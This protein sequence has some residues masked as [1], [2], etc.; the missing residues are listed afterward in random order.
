VG[1]EMSRI[2]TIILFGTFVAISSGCQQHTSPP[3]RTPIPSTQPTDP[4]SAAKAEIRE[5][6]YREL[7]QKIPLG[8]TCYLSFGETKEGWIDPTNEFIARFADTGLRIGKPSQM[9]LKQFAE[10]DNRHILDPSTHT[11]AYVYWVK[12]KEWL[13]DDRVVVE[14]GR[15]GGPLD[16]FGEDGVMSRKNG[17]WIFEPIGSGWVS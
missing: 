8:Q 9:Q 17:R 12:F 15:Y 5:A 11:A 3:P 6:A 13:A 4:H 2:L 7:L 14:I 16:A 1:I 10:P